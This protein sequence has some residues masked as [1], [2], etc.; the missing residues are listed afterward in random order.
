MHKHSLE[1]A[2]IA[3]C[4]RV[5]R[6]EGKTSQITIF[7]HTLHSLFFA[8]S[9]SYLIFSSMHF[10]PPHFLSLFIFF[11]SNGDGG[12]IKEEEEDGEK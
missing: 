9:L 4:M 8:C 5:E 1:L 3:L 12:G 2:G 10:L 6:K 11:I 7:P